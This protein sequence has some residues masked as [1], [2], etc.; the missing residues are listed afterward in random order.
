[1]T[2]YASYLRPGGN[3]CVPGTFERSGEPVV[4]KLLRNGFPRKIDF[5]KPLATKRLVS[6][7]GI[8]SARRRKFND[9]QGHGWHESTWKAVLKH[10]TDC[11][12]IADFSGS[13]KTKLTTLVG[14]ST[15]RQSWSRDKWPLRKHAAAAPVLGRSVIRVSGLGN[16]ACQTLGPEPDP[17]HVHVQ[18]RN[19]RRQASTPGAAG[20]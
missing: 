3:R 19:W 15:R 11:E 1:M 12:W 17:A 7:E 13:T 10:Q 18:P 16:A 9:M 4:M 8:E 20:E 6:A 2:T 14:R 5:C